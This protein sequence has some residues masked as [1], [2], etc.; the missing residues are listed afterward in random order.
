MTFGD[1]LFGLSVLL[2][3]GSLC[4]VG[5]LLLRCRWK[6]ARRLLVY[7][8]AFLGAYGLVLVGVSLTSPRRML[9]LRQPRC[10]DDWCLQLDRV[11]WR[12]TVGRSPAVAVARG[13]YA[14]VTVR[15]LSR[16]RGASQRAL[17]ARIYVVAADGRRYDPD[18]AAQRALA[19][20]G[21]GG[22]PLASEVAPGGSFTRTVAFDVLTRTGHLDLVV[23]HGLFPSLL[24]IGDAQS[25]L[26]RPVVIAVSGGS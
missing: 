26:H 7:L 22:L 3:V 23:Q 2:T 5:Y 4:R 16:A 8:G 13:R 6:R 11:A 25:F 9:G 10:F 20:Q 12:A 18:G 14:V 1:L 15:V 21:A 24:V 19:A 17:D